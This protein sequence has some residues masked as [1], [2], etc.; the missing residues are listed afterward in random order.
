MSA[1]RL[2][3]L[4]VMLGGLTTMAGCG[5]DESSTANQD[6]AFTE[7]TVID[8]VQL[9]AAQ[10]CHGVAGTVGGSLS[11]LKLVDSEGLHLLIE[12]GD[13]VCIDTMESIAAEL[14]AIEEAYIE[15]TGEADQTGEIPQNLRPMALTS[16]KSPGDTE[17]DPNPQ[18][19]LETGVKITSTKTPVRPGLPLPGDSTGPTPDSPPDNP[20]DKD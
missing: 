8:A 13:P 7:M 16:P 3:I 2:L 18:P 15:Q 9:G 20:S 12:D 5:L 4:G 11:I 10:S 6:A 19:A 1:Y 14:E 17:T